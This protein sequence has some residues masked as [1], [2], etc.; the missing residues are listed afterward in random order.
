ALS[1]D[2]AYMLKEAIEKA[3][4]TDHEAI[5]KELKNIEFSG[6]TGNLKFDENNNPVKAISMIKIVD[7]DYTFDTLVEPK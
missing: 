6:V 4:S 3:G 5:I 1:Y 7:G 2:G